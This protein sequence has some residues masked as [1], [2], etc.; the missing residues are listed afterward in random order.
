[1][2]DR[3]LIKQLKDGVQ[4]AY[5]SIFENYKSLVFYYCMDVLNNR[6][7]AEDILQ[8]TFV[9]FFNNV[10]KLEDNSN[11]KLIL[12]SLAKR[13]SIDLYRKKQ[14]DLSVLVD[15][16]ETFA[17]NDPQSEVNVLTTLNN[18]LDP[19]DGKIMTLKI[20][21]KYTFM[22]ISEELGLSLGEVQSHYYKNIK[23]L[24]KHYEEERYEYREKVC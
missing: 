8:E 2:N 4:N 19:I 22:E 18:L 23:I 12:V 16:V 3:H 7:D 1:M 24:K 11:I 9:E 10:G 21:Y 5:F 14:K 6:E 13:R 15:N 20:L 17:S